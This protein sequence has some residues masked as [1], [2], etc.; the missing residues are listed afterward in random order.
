MGPSRTVGARLSSRWR[1]HHLLLLLLPSL[2]AFVASPAPSSSSSPAFSSAV[3]STH[4]D[5]NPHAGLSPATVLDSLVFSSP[6]PTF[7]AFAAFIQEMQKDIITTLEDEDGTGATFQVDKWTR[8]GGLSHGATCVLE[9]GAFIEKGAVSVSIIKGVLSKERAAAMSS[10]GRDLGGNTEGGVQY[11]AAALSLVLHS[12]NPHLPTF[13]SDV[14]YFECQGRGWFGGGAD[15]TPYYL[16]DGDIAAFHA[17]YRGLCDAFD[18]TK[19]LFPRYKKWCDSYFYLPGR[20]EHR[21]VG[22]IFFDD[23]E[24]MEGGMEEGAE[25]K[26][27]EKEEEERGGEGRKEG[28]VEKARRFTEAVARSFMPSYLSL[29]RRR[30]DEP[31]DEKQRQWMLLRRGRYLEFNLLYD[32][33]VKFG[34]AG[35]RFESVMV[36]AP[37][38]AA[39]KYNHQPEEGSEEARLLAVLK[40]PRDW[41]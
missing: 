13:R 28:R 15:L 37:P 8:D 24:G 25:G 9:G 6:S 19:A 34:L 11:A 27:E 40:T 32:R 29:V 17:L 12:A 22:G 33:G 4:R 23:L 31:F 21:G 18:P 5:I 39:W 1:F 16:H 2:H 41:A 36:S 30:R 35:G 7:D 20:Q 10:R 14:R 26:E 3:K 38:M